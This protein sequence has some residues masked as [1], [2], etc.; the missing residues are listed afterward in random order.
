[1]VTAIVLVCLSKALLHASIVIFYTH[2]Y[3]IKVFH[4]FHLVPLFHLP[5]GFVILYVVYVLVVFLG[6]LINEKIIKKK[7]AKQVFQVRMS[8]KFPIL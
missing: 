3:Y 4:F 8:G 7:L 6:R 1:M 2:G 5:T